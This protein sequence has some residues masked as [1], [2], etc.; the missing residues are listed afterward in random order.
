MLDAGEPEIP[1]PPEEPTKPR[2]NATRQ[3]KE[4]YEDDYDKYVDKRTRW[5]NKRNTIL[6]EFREDA[7]E[8]AKK[9][10]E[11]GKRVVMLSGDVSPLSPYIYRTHYNL[12]D[13]V[14]LHGDHGL[15]E[16]MVVSEYIRTED[17]NGDRGYPG[18]IMP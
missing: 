9:T 10:L 18:L 2:K 7:V 14:S 15:V 5:R 1:D 11:A 17:E 8:D 16:K 3:E 4:K 13:T 6:Q 12:G